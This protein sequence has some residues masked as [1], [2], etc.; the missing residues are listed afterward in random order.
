MP[1]APLLLRGRTTFAVLKDLVMTGV[2]RF[3]APKP[4]GVVVRREGREFLDERAKLVRPD[5]TQSIEEHWR[6]R[7]IEWNT[8]APAPPK[9]AA[10]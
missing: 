6:R 10:C 1:I 9:S 3:G 5:F 2:S 8:V 4:E 7:R